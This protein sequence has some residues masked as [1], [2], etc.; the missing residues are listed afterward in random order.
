M[1][2][3]LASAGINHV[4]AQHG[5]ARERLSAF[6]GSHIE[7]RTP[8]LPVLKLAI[9]ASGTIEPA[10]PE[11]TPD[12][13]VA[14]KP[15]AL[16]LVLAR[17]EA[18]LAEVELS[19]P[20]DLA[21][22]VRFLLRHLSWDVE[23]DLSRLLGDVLAHR[24]ALAA[25]DF[26]AWQKDAGLRA[27]QNLAEYLTEERALLAHPEALKGMGEQIERLREDCERVEK[28]IERLE[29]AGKKAR[30]DPC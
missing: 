12:L 24:T 3:R 6:G 18:A 5:W 2:R 23:E 10:A 17:D 8:P 27:A 22:C 1:I 4:L 29:R 7:L 14:I 9:L 11:A 30:R 25:R 21:D 13:V 19:G 28:R 20:A 15:A 16:P 26:V